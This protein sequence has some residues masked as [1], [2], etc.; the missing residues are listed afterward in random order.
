MAVFFRRLYGLRPGLLRNLYAR[1]ESREPGDSGPEQPE[2]N[3]YRNGE[4]ARP[5][6]GRPWEIHEPRAASRSAGFVVLVVL[7]G[8]EPVGASRSGV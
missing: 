7:T 8:F 4:A 1:R 6:G 5:S 2:T 3:C